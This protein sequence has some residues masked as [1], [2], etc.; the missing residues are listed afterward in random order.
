MMAGA[1]LIVGEHEPRGY[2]YFRPGGV[3]VMSS[4][5]YLI[6]TATVG[7]E[8]YLSVFGTARRPRFTNNALF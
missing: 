2:S 6:T 8:N 4:S 1:C 3:R 7:A 5:G